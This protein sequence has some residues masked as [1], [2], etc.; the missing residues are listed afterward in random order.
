MAIVSIGQLYQDFKDGNVITEPNLVDLIDSCYNY[1]TPSRNGG[2]VYELNVTLDADDISN[3]S[4]K[5]GVSPLEGIEILPPAG[6][7]KCYIPAYRSIFVSYEAVDNNEY[8]SVPYGS[9]NSLDF[10]YPN[11][12]YYQLEKK[13]QTIA[14]VP[15][16]SD[17]SS[18]WCN[19]CQGPCVEDNQVWQNFTGKESLNIDTYMNSF[20]S[21]QWADQGDKSLSLDTLENA[22]L[23]VGTTGLLSSARKRTNGKIKIKMWYRIFDI[24]E[25]VDRTYGGKG[26][27]TKNVVPNN[28]YM[29]SMLGAGGMALT[30]DDPGYGHRLNMATY[31]DMDNW[32][33]VNGPGGDCLPD[34]KYQPLESEDAGVQFRQHRDAYLKAS[35]EYVLAYSAGISGDNADYCWVTPYQTVA[36]DYNKLKATE[37]PSIGGVFTGNEPSAPL[38][39]YYI[40]RGKNPYNSFP[41]YSGPDAQGIFGWTYSY[42]VGPTRPIYEL[43]YDDDS[44][45]NTAIAFQYLELNIWEFTELLIYVKDSGTYAD[46][47]C[48]RITSI[49]IING[50]TG[51]QIGD[52]VTI[53]NGAG[54]VGTGCVAAV[55]ETGPNDEIQKITIANVDQIAGGK[56]Y[57]AGV[58][59]TMAAGLGDG[60]AVLGNP[61][62]EIGQWIELESWNI[63]LGYEFG[64]VLVTQRS[65]R[66]AYLKALNE[67]SLAGSP[68]WF[69][70]EVPQFQFDKY[71]IQ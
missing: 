58:T 57:Q 21:T 16:M 11:R 20:V 23:Y 65:V 7:G 5:D 29:T 38:A 52:P 46:G 60:N 32:P 17:P 55:S 37:I 59:A 71:L 8:V 12:G 47:T 43:T 10:Y 64:D 34:P 40:Y 44:L 2:L 35:N 53:T 31:S 63:G 61:V 62:L 9:L 28:K 22:P 26:Y 4:Y 67:L 45:V 51:Y 36:G 56:Y 27:S 24:S 48:K 18:T 54:G 19:R 68:M 41:N 15:L 14:S 66:D 33:G 3:M 39:H 25:M 49:P 13:R 1:D 6:K 70:A 50:G 42:S 69:S 30:M